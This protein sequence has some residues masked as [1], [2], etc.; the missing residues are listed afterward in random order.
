MQV[1]T[2]K[3]LIEKISGKF[4]PTAR[5]RAN[6]AVSDFDAVRDEAFEICNSEFCEAAT[7][8]GGEPKIS[9]ADWERLDEIEATAR[10]AREANLMIQYRDAWRE[11]A[12][13]AKEIFDSLAETKGN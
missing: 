3:T 13:T 11:Y 12:A 6:W 7:R 10:D 8:L 2:M 5:S 1:F 4:S 9:A